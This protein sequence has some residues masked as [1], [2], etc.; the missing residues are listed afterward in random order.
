[1]F[2]EW[3]IYSHATFQIRR[4]YARC[5]SHFTLCS[6][7]GRDPADLPCRVSHGACL[8][9]YQVEETGQAGHSY[10]GQVSLKVLQE[11]FPESLAGHPVEE[12]AFRL[13]A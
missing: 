13:A 7:A 9:A 1:M 5:S 12:T 8:A 11:A 10:R 2:F 4:R 3:C 6:S